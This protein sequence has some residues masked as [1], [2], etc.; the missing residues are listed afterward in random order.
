[1]K[2]LI[3]T[4]TILASLAVGGMLG[5]QFGW[6]GTALATPLGMLIGSL[7]YWLAETFERP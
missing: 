4:I 5:M 7:G 3:Y 2:A 6:W 1:M